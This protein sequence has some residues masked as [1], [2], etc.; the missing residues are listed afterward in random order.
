MVLGDW[1]TCAFLSPTHSA[2]SRSPMEPRFGGAHRQWNFMEILHHVQGPILLQ[3]H[4]T[5]MSFDTTETSLPCQAMVPMR[6]ERAKYW[7]DQ[8]H[9]SSMPQVKT[10]GGGRRTLDTWCFGE[11][12][13]LRC[14]GIQI[15][16][17]IYIYRERKRECN[18]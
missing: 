1:V 3:R 5:P 17:Q 9:R 15:C 11:E 2:D 8:A 16:A 13:P 7:L 4:S 10:L 14:T 18:S 6:P 12:P